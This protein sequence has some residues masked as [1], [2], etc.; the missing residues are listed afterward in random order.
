MKVNPFEK[1][2]EKPKICKK[3]VLEM[4]YKGIRQSLG[5]N[6][7]VY[8]CDNCGKEELVLSH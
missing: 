5:M 2:E 7:K 8:K 3:C 6:Y 4:K 1:E